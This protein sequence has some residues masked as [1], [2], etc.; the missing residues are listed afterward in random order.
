[1]NDSTII[2]L[3]RKEGICERVGQIGDV[4]EM[5]TRGEG[6]RVFCIWVDFRCGFERGFLELTGRASIILSRIGIEIVCLEEFL[7]V[8]PLDLPEASKVDLYPRVQEVETC[9]WTWGR[10]ALSSKRTSVYHSNSK[11]TLVWWA[12]T[13][14]R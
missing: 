6:V 11:E 2:Q 9:S 7:H 5:G 8:L 10:H 12:T 14:D 1:M 13:N 4:S 3:C